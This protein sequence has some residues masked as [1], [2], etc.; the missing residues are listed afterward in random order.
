MSLGPK[1]FHWNTMKNLIFHLL[2]G[3]FSITGIFISDIRKA[4][5]LTG[6]IVKGHVNI[7]HWATFGE[8]VLNIF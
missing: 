3:S 1:N 2:I 6:A 5:G 7:T 4:A 8:E